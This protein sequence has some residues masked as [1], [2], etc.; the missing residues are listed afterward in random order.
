MKRVTAFVGSAHRRNTHE[1]VVQFL[2][3]L[4]ALGDVEAEIVTLSDY[5]LRACRGCECCIEKGEEFC[6]LKD[7]RDVL[8]DKIAASDGVVFASPNYCGHVSGLMK[9]F[10]D[11]FVSVCHRPRYFGKVCTSIVTQR[12]TGGDKIV[13]YFDILAGTLGF[14]VVKGTCFTILD[15]MTEKQQQ[16]RDRARA[17]QAQQFYVRLSKPAYP[18]PTWLSLMVFRISRNAIGQIRDDNHRD[19]RYFTEKGWLTSDY[20]YPTHLGP[21]KKVAGKLVDSLAPTLQRMLAS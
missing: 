6:P 21:L 5:T 7:D 20:Y 11:R 18:A 8:M 19:Y 9:T 15:E 2:N 3:A 16:K 10:I 12:I 17:R 4:Q 1:A 14:S 13:E